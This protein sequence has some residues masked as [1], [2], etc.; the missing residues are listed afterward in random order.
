[1]TSITY[2]QVIDFLEGLSIV[3]INALVRQLEDRW[4]VSASASV[5]QPVLPP[6]PV[7]EPSTHVDLMLTATGSQRIPVLRELRN[8]T[9]WGLRE[10][11]DLIDHLPAPVL[12]DI[13]RERAAL[14][15]E[16][17]EALGAETSLEDSR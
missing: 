9:G 12:E 7:T 2:A 5:V 1:M 11:R 6:S 3:E 14:A 15:A 10:V 17:L 16:A 4:Q 8:L 13:P